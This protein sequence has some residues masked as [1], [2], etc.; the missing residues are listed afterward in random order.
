MMADGLI[1]N[2]NQLQ[3][4]LTVEHQRGIKDLVVIRDNYDKDSCELNNTQNDK[5]T[6]PIIIREGTDKC[7]EETQRHSQK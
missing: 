7:S 2:K 6:I 5:K 1:L 4:D 3:Q